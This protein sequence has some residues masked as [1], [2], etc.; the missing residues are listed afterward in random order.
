MINLKD[1]KISAFRAS[2]T[3]TA[4]NNED[5][6]IINYFNSK[7]NGLI[8]DV[9]AADGVSVS[10]SFKLINEY[11]WSAL[12]VEPYSIYFKQ[13][14]YLYD[15][16]NKVILENIAVSSVSK[17]ATLFIKREQGCH[18]L[19]EQETKPEDPNDRRLGPDIGQEEVS[20]LT[21]NDLFKKHNIKD[22]DALCI[23]TEG[24]DLA[25]LRGLN[26]EEYDPKIIIVEYAP[27]KK[28]PTTQKEFENIIGP[29]YKLMKNTGGNYI[30]AHN[31]I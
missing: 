18:S 19:R 12:L 29:N 9:G 6:F 22:I 20:V 10:N 31:K 13:L 15:N 27:L 14:K 8:V 23:D 2:R 26:F 11:D 1:P 21:L 7:K 28:F 16:N 17:K 3:F 4:S 5:D 24:N 25:V 30:F